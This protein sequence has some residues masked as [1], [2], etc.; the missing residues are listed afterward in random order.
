MVASKF[1]EGISDFHPK[2]WPVFG[3]MVKLSLSLKAAGKKEETEGIYPN[4]W[5]GKLPLLKHWKLKKA[6]ESMEE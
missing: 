5:D 2:P 6:R 1:L 3:E 4:F